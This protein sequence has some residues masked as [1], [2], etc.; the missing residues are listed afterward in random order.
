TRNWQVVRILM[1]A[2]YIHDLLDIN[3]R[4]GKA[5]QLMICVVRFDVIILQT[6]IHTSLFSLAARVGCMLCDMSH[7]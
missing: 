5:S 4:G 6:K 3:S 2:L 7:N 1:H